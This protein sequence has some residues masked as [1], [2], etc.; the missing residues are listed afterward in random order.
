MFEDKNFTEGPWKTSVS[1]VHGS[2]KKA[3]LSAHRRGIVAEFKQPGRPEDEIL[4]NLQLAKTAPEMVEA[5]EDL[6]EQLTW[7]GDQYTG[8]KADEDVVIPRKDY[9]AMIK[10]IECVNEKALCHKPEVV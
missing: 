8:A 6:W 9:D 1:R 3:M 2:I 7:H 10:L 4:A 5:L